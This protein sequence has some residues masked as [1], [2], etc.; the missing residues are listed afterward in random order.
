MVSFDG[1]NNQTLL[2]EKLGGRRG[3]PILLLFR[4]KY[5]QLDSIE[6]MAGQKL[7]NPVL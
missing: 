3:I 7:R 1:E 5:I 2:A 6:R 4:A